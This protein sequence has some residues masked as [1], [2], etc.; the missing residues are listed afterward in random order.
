M[1]IDNNQIKKPYSHLRSFKPKGDA[2]S[3][4]AR[5][6]QKGSASPKRKVA[7][8]LVAMKRKGPTAMTPE[9]LERKALAMATNPE[10]SAY[11]IMQMVQII[12]D[13][14]DLTTGLRIQL[15]RAMN[16]AHRTIH[17]TKQHI[18]A[19]IESVTV[20]INEPIERPKDLIKDD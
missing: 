3:D 8:Q 1:E 18:T 15:L 7:Q 17:G 2:W 13:R 5:A 19:K 9:N 20:T 14:E 12:G 10:T 6:N 4:A 11:T 16:D